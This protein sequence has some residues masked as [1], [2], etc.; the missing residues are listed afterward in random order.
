[1]PQQSIICVIGHRERS[2]MA[3]PYLLILLL[4]GYMVFYPSADGQPTK[5]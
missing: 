2:N 4:F 5:Y 3:V 1:M